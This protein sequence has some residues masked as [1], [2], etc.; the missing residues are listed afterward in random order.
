M[1]QPW[2]PWYARDFAA[3][4]PVLLMTLEAEGAYRRLLDHQ[5]LHGSIPDDL[6]QLGVI[7]KNTPPARMKKLWSA[8]RPCFAES[9]PGRLVN[10]KLERVREEQEEF[11]ERRSRAGRKGNAKRWAER[12]PSDRNAMTERSQCDD[13]A[14]DVR[15]ANAS[16]PKSKAKAESKDT[17]DAV[18]D[19]GAP[20]GWERFREAVPEPFQASLREALRAAKSSNGLRATLVA[21]T[22]AMGQPAD[23]V[24]TPDVVGQ[25]LH[26]AWQTGDV[27]PLRLRTFAGRIVADRTKDRP[28]ETPGERILRM[29]RGAA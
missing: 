24:F 4:E 2:Y 9:E 26:E 21:M 27:T 19:G 15:V 13:D 7:C 3:D 17:A 1:K 10:P 22:E 29:A 16:P 12:S 25:A 20:R 23:Q 11:H 8:I 5:W 14:T 6:K 18:S 28:N